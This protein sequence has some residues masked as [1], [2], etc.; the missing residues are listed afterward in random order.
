M[1]GTGGFHLKSLKGPLL[2]AT[3]KTIRQLSFF[4]NS[5]FDGFDRVHFLPSDDLGDMYRQCVDAGIY[6]AGA[7]DVTLQCENDKGHYSLRRQH[8][9]NM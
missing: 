6:F 5:K 4:C 8:Q 1:T 3:A 2:T 7:A 9:S